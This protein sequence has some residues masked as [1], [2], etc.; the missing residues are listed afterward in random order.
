MNINAL[1]KIE[2]DLYEEPTIT[3]TIAMPIRTP[4]PPPLLSSYHSRLAA[5]PIMIS[6]PTHPCSRSTPIFRRTFSSRIWLRR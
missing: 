2:A 4:I 5:F 1:V 3:I 6:P